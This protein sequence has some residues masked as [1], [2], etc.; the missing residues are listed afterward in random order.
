[1]GHLYFKD[2]E[3]WLGGQVCHL[4]IKSMEMDT[5][6]WLI[7]CLSKS[8]FT[9]KFNALLIETSTWLIE[10]SKKVREFPKAFWVLSIGTPEATIDWFVGSFILVDDFIEVPWEGE[11]IGMLLGAK[12][13]INSQSFILISQVDITLLLLRTHHSIWEECPLLHTK[14]HSVHHHW[15][16]HQ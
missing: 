15:S 11:H 16:S 10:L 14:N 2:F 3:V 1:M 8:W 5:L 7:Y 13:S 6:Q 12:L 4:N 9:Y